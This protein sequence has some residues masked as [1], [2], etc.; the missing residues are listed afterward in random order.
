MFKNRKDPTDLQHTFPLSLRGFISCVL[1]GGPHT[2]LSLPLYE[3]V[4]ALC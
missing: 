1:G 2:A 3:N 4:Y